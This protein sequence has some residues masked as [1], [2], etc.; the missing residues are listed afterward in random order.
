[1]KACGLF[2]GA[3]EKRNRF[4]DE[5]PPAPSVYA[6]NI[7]QLVRGHQ[8]ALVVAPAQLIHQMLEMGRQIR[9][10]RTKLLLQPFA[11]G[12]TDRSARLAVDVLNALGDS[13]VHNEF[14]FLAPLQ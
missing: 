6:E 14:R 8:A 11:Y 12:V 1:L 10:L 9:R 5:I 2:T 7:R 13:A 3:A 4:M